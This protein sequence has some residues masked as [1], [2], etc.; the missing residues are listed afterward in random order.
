MSL[1][2]YYHHHVKHHHRFHVAVLLTMIA[3]AWVAVP[4][5][6]RFVDSLSSYDPAGYEPKD[7]AR[8]QA[9]G[10]RDGFSI[11]GVSWDD[12]LKIVLFILA[13]LAWLAVAPSINRPSRAPRR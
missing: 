9:L 4:M 8:A 13:G 10:M 2:R 6:A 7:A 11:V 12:I 5:V 1:R 3:V